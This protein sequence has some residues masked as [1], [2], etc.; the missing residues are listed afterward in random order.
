MFDIQD[1]IGSTKVAI[2]C[3][4]LVLIDD[5]PQ[6]CFED[7]QLYKLLSSFI[8]ESKKCSLNSIELVC[9]NIFVGLQDYFANLTGDSSFGQIFMGE[10]NKYFTVYSSGTIQTEK[11]ALEF[12][13]KEPYSDGSAYTFLNL[14]DKEEGMF[15]EANYIVDS[16]SLNV[17][18]TDLLKVYPV[19]EEHFMARSELIFDN[20][21]FH[22][23]TL[24]TLKTVKSGTFRDH[25]IQI[26]QGLHT[27][28]YA[29][30]NLASTTSDNEAD[31][32]QIS[33]WSSQF[34]D[35][36]LSC[37]RQGSNKLR[38]DFSFDDSDDTESINCESHLK[39]NFNNN[40]DKIEERGKDGA[41]YNR[42]YFGIHMHNGAKKLLVAHIGEHL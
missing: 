20:L 3:D 1:V 21:T 42:L 41:H 27:L 5:S 10:F 22:P 31:R 26:V 35:N 40:G 8:E 33:E 30:E 16:A 15:S 6:S 12:A 37:T 14:S 38:Y 19:S 11:E 23:D 13:T 17:F 2:V 4:S 34:G 36:T 18:N 9:E 24:E 32:T 28:K 29:Q 39:L 25:T 7:T